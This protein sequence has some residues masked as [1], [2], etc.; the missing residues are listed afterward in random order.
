MLPM[1]Y[2][3]NIV[4]KNH[5]ICYFC[6]IDCCNLVTI[7]LSVSLILGSSRT[8]TFFFPFFE[9]YDLFLKNK[10]CFIRLQKLCGAT[11][12]LE[13]VSVKLINKK[14]PLS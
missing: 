5:N 7:T 2:K 14:I 12:I 8:D 1:F 9:K 4:L 10:I 11:F 3:S 13:T 6:V